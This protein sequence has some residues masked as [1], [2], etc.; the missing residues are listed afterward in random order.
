MSVSSNDPFHVNFEVI[1]SDNL[2]ALF[3]L[4]SSLLLSLIY[5]HVTGLITLAFC[6]TA[7]TLCI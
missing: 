3:S 7:F 5:S 6:S 1:T 2:S 4:I